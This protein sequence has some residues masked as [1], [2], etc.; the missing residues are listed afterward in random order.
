M[1]VRP[2]RLSLALSVV[3]LF[4][5]G[6]AAERTPVRLDRYGDPLPPGARAR[7]GS[8]RFRTN[9]V[10]L[11][12]GGGM[13]VSPDGGVLVGNDRK[14]EVRILDP[15]SGKELRR[16]RAGCFACFSPDGRLMATGSVD[17]GID[18]WEVRTGKRSLRLA[19]HKPPSAPPA[20]AV[21]YDPL[22][23]LQVA[24]SPDGKCLASWGCDHTLRRWDLT[25]G[26]ELRSWPLKAKDIYCYTLSPDA[27]V[28]LERGG[29]DHR[30]R[31]WDATAGKEIRTLPRQA[32]RVV[33]WRFSQDGR[34]LA[35]GLEGGRAAPVRGGQ[36]PRTLESGR[37][38]SALGSCLLCPRRQGGR[39][40]RHGRA[41]A[42]RGHRTGS[43]H[44]AGGG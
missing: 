3:L 41:F 2:V 10:F 34:R 11:S 43:P 5:A 19:G 17:G 22:K 32:G 36:W 21:D 30:L 12:Y 7:L 44:L 8:L 14:G 16:I 18:L 25:T 15:V 29:D 9:L 24:F 4:G 38:G 13:H 20:G 26:K 27:R 31:L 23:F 1:S 28:L 42:G 6:P 33:E 37:V 39:H 35:V 40:R